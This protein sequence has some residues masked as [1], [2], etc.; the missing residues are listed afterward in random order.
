MNNTQKLLVI[1]VVFLILVPSTVSATHYGN[2]T[3]PG[4]HYNGTWVIA[5]GEM[6]CIGDLMPNNLPI[7]HDPVDMQ[8][9]VTWIIVSNTT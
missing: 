3:I 2:A 4:L 6:L 7:V 1:A 8:G 5:G 9:R